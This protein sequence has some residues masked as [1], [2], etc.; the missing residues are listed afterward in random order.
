MIL[1]PDPFHV[2]LLGFG[3]YAVEGLEKCFP[4]VMTN[5][6]RAHNMNKSGQITGGKF[7]GPS[8]KYILGEEI[9]IKIYYVTFV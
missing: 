9:S 5:F 3:N 4:D 2:N 8:I 7:N 6:Y 1:P